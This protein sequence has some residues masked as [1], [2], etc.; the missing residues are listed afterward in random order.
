MNE[1]DL[2]VV[3]MLYCPKT[4]LNIL[5]INVDTMHKRVKFLSLKTQS[6]NNIN[7]NNCTNY[8]HFYSSN[9]IGIKGWTSVST[10]S[11]SAAQQ[12]LWVDL[13]DFALTD[14]TAAR[15]TRMWSSVKN[16]DW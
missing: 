2:D 6:I 10:V 16:W 5:S 1:S 9:N 4:A 14:A 8:D 15:K 12:T 13:F 3:Y 7:N 11:S